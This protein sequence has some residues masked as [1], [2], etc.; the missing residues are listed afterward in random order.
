MKA[1]KFW[2]EGADGRDVMAWVIKPAKNVQLKDGKVPMGKFHSFWI[3]VQLELT[4]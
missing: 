1:E 2:F 3:P 4:K